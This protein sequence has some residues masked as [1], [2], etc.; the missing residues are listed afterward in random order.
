[1]SAHASALDYNPSGVR[2]KKKV[3]YFSNRPRIVINTQ[4]ATGFGSSEP[5]SGQ[6]LIFRHGAF[7]KCAHYG[8]PFA[9]KEF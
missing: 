4:L 7:G 5:S 2:I 8:I 6:F 3:G 1:M 9:Y